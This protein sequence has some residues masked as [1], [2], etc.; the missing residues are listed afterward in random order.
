MASYFYCHRRSYSV[1]HFKLHSVLS[2]M[3][4][5]PELSC[6]AGCF[7]DR[8]GRFQARGGPSTLPSSP[9]AGFNMLRG[10]QREAAE[11]CYAFTLILFPVCAWVVSGKRDSGKS[12]GSLTEIHKVHHNHLRPMNKRGWCLYWSSRNLPWSIPHS[13]N[14]ICIT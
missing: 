14:C 13:Y 11:C 9:R 1:L 4:A 6:W 5:G 10:W 8:E 7:L 3:F 2:G 12:T